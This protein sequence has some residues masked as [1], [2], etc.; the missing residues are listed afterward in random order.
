MTPSGSVG[1]APDYRH[2]PKTVHARPE[3]DVV[4]PGGRFKWYDVVRDDEAIADADRALAR[5]TVVAALESGAVPAALGFV[6]LHLSGGYHFLAVWTWRNENELWQTLYV[7]GNGEFRAVVGRGH[8]PVMC[9]WEMGPVVHEQQAWVRFLGTARDA[10]AVE[11]YLAD[12][13]SGPV[14]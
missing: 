6:V 7:R 10:G 5:R 9:V 2:S 8:K 14:G 4:V 11:A 13:M 3:H 1:V 12:R